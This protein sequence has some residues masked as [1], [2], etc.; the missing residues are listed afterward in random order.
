MKSVI[1]TKVN[2]VETEGSL[3]LSLSVIHYPPFQEQLGFHIFLTCSILVKHPQ[4]AR[5]PFQSIRGCLSWRSPFRLWIQV[6]SILLYYTL[7]AN[8]ELLKQ[9]FLM[10]MDYFTP[11]LPF[12]IGTDLADNLKTSPRLIKTHL[13][14]HFV[15]K[16]F[17]EQ[18]CKVSCLYVVF[19]FSNCL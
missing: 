16:S 9:N 7:S 2:R 15:P 4:S 13:P 5:H 17:W 6:G 11:S 12:H 10:I 3:Q 8:V 14:V 19:Y 18:N 1:H